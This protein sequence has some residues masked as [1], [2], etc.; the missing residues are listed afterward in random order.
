MGNCCSNFPAH[1]SVLLNNSSF[2]PA[3]AF[4]TVEKNSDWLVLDQEGD[5]LTMVLT[6]QEDSRVVNTIQWIQNNG[7]LL[8]N[9]LVTTST[10]TSSSS[11]SQ[12][13]WSAAR[14]ASLF[15]A[16]GSLEHLE[17]VLLHEI[18]TSTN[19][20]PLRL[21]SG[22]LKKSQMTLK[23]MYLVGHFMADQ[24]ECQGFATQLSHQTKLQSFA[25]Y[26][27]GSRDCIVDPILQA[28][29]TL[30]TLTSLYFHGNMPNP[31]QTDTMIQVG[32]MSNLE[33]LTIHSCDIKSTNIVA[34][35][36]TLKTANVLKELTI[37]EAF[38]MFQGQTSCVQALC[39]L[40]QK[41]S[42]LQ[43]FHVWFG[44][45]DSPILKQFATVLSQN[46]NRNTSLTNFE[47]ALIWTEYDDETAKEF[48]SMMQTN[49]QL[50]NLVLRGYKG[51][52][53]L[54]IYF[55][56]RLN[57]TGRKRFIERCEQ[58]SSE[59]WIQML[60]NVPT[61]VGNDVEKKRVAA[62]ADAP[63]D[64][65]WFATSWTYYYLRMNPSLCS[66]SSL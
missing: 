62:L 8:R 19:P 18:G 16:I 48:Y 53:R 58:M 30:T 15:V 13:I 65:S 6:L 27:N 66:N 56:V 44:F 5:G 43:S 45:A 49:Y 54:P 46:Q 9:I 22:V 28:A 26:G 61:I 31:V 35:A 20:V 40:L 38:E 51:Q 57:Q 14:I 11:N 24:A 64:K 37:F 17:V 10:K 4:Q 32:R 52:W 41:S 3:S 33:T 23:Q 47:T 63:N 21:L 39:Q 12:P 60:T 34:L 7:K 59:E 29:A 42:T 2:G 50:D 36:E 55:Y 25:L 1:L